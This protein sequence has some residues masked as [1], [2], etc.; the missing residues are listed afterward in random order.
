MSTPIEAARQNVDAYFIDKGGRENE[1]LDAFEAAIRAD[2]EARHEATNAY[3]AETA[4]ALNA[5]VDVLTVQRDLLGH[6]LETIGDEAE[7][8]SPT[9]R[10]VRDVFDRLAELTAA[11]DAEASR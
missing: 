5:R 2:V 3:L 6:A 1:A 9:A 10:Y 8:G 7:V 4:V 11:L